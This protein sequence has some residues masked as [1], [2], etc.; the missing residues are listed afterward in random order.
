MAFTVDGIFTLFKFL[1]FLNIPPGIE[2]KALGITAEYIP[3]SS[4]APSPQ[5]TNALFSGKYKDIPFAP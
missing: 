1:Q 5:L 2:V 4:K 3:D